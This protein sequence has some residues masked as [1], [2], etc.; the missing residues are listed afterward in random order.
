MKKYIKKFFSWLQKERP[1]K[2][3]I[4]YLYFISL[5]AFLIL[6][7][8]SHFLSYETPLVGIPLFFLIQAFGQAFLEVGLF[9]LIAYL[10]KRWAPRWTHLLFISFCFFFLLLH[11]TDFTLARL[12]DTSIAY[13]IKFFLGG[14]IEHIVTAFQALNMNS[15]MILIILGTLFA[16]PILGLLFYWL[17]YRVAHIK[18]LSI[19][20]NQIAIGLCSVFV[21][22]FLLDV[23]VHPFLNR[24]IYAKYQKALP[25]KTTFISPSPRCIQL[26]APLASFRNEEETLANIPPLSI[27][28]RP[29]IY[30]FIIETLRKDFVTDEIAPEL[31]SFAKENIQ[32][33]SSFSNANSTHLSWFAIFHSDIP[34]HWTAMRD[35]W[36]TGSIP[37]QILKKIG[38]KIRVYSS[39]DLRYFNIDKLIFGQKRELA[40]HIEEYTSN[41][42]IEPCD[43]DALAFQSFSR[44]LQEEDA[45]EGNLFIF[46]LDSTHSE[47]S[48]PANLPPKF[49]PISKE[50]DY[51]SIGPKS[52]ELEFIKNRYRNSIHYVDRLMGDF[53][54]ELKS[55][56]LYEKALIA[57]TGD[58]GE[59]FFEEGALF[60]GTHLNHYQ[61]SVP[62][63]FKFPE[64]TQKNV[65]TQEA[66]H[67][68]LFPSILNYLTDLNDFSSLFD[69]QSIFSPTRWPYRISVIHNGPDTPCEF[70]IDGKGTKLQLRLLPNSSIYTQTSLEIIDIKTS[71]QNETLDS[72][73]EAHFPNA[74]PSL[75]EKKGRVLN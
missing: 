74:I 32:F 45:K 64:K 15:T 62:L 12:M 56:K 17:T 25:F 49:E 46:F 34:Y 11:F 35:S 30:L 59:E 40:D 39:S 26:P 61:T 73:I 55:K 42:A 20:L 16:L 7:S 68:D 27:S 36:K 75:L 41:R 8:L 53:F 18:P 28:H 60:H 51:L 65:L 43:R 4:N 44:D 24:H 33:P 10:L 2:N 72:Y 70:A 63:F 21:S 31:V 54:K 66:T 14:G 67:L 29:N 69:G 47:Y 9:L 3:E 38:Y 37:L 58:H 5:L 57:I 19:S 22:L 13:P 71:P 52:R 1:R 48:Y 23:V 50:I 6:L